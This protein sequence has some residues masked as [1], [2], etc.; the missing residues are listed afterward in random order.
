MIIDYSFGKLSLV[1]QPLF[2]VPL[3]LPQ[4]IPDIETGLGLDISDA[5]SDL[6][7]RVPDVL[8]DNQENLRCSGT[9][10]PAAIGEL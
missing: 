8:S 10:L 3:N 7:A 1:D 4:N 6:F 9:I 2:P 5:C